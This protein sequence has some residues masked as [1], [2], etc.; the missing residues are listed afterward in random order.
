[1]TKKSTAH[2]KEFS[3]MLADES[4]STFVILIIFS[5]LFG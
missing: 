1:M 5:K 2:N 3:A 4:H